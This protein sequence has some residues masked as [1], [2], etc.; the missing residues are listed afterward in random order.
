MPLAR[1]RFHPAPARR[2]AW[3][4][5]LLVIALLV[6]AASTARA[7]DPLEQQVLSLVNRHRATRGLPA[8][9]ADARIAREAR[10]HSAAMASGTVPFG[11]AGFAE[12]GA[13]LRRVMP[14]RSSAENV[15]SSLGYD[16]PAGEMVRGW[17]ASSGHRKN[18]EGPYETTG[19]GVA[20]SARGQI[21]VTQIFVAD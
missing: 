14:C 15:A 8:L 7:G 2:A 13:A 17:L 10:R 1:A 11:H 3:W 18:I 4:R 20:R 5:A 6:G 21:Y 19:V 12:R 16:D 9:R